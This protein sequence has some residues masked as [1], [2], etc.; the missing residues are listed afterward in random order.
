MPFNGAGSYSPPATDFPAVPATL[1]ESTKFNNVINDI[2]TALSTCI[3]KD[4]QTTVT[5]NIPFGG[6]RLTGVGAGTARTD[7]ANVGQLQDNTA[8]W[9]GTAAGTADAITLTPAPAIAAYVAGMSFVY[10]SG[11]AV[12]T[13]AMT[14]AISGL[15][16]KAIQ[17]NGGAL[18]A[19]DHPANRWF[20][21]VYDGAAFQ[22]N[23]VSWP[24]LAEL[25]T[26]KGDIIVWTGAGVPV[27]LAVGADTNLLV[28][29]STQP[30]GVKWSAF[31]LAAFGNQA[32]NTFLAGPASGAAATPGWRVGTAAD[33]M[34][35]VLL[36]TGT[37]SNSTSLDFTGLDG[38][39]D[40]HVFELVD[41]I[42]VNNGVNFGVRI[43]QDNGGS[44]KSG[45][46]DY[47]QML[48][49]I[50]DGGGVQSAGA[51]GTRIPLNSGTLSNATGG[52]SGRVVF[53]KLAGTTLRHEMTFQGTYRHSGPGMESVSG[54]G[55]YIIDTAAIN[56]IRFF[57]DTN[58]IS[59][60]VIRLFGRRKA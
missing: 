58:N 35:E 48:Y 43:S 15:A 46:A 12:N 52:W 60:G 22:L 6:F 30:G 40:E 37:A 45:A 42:A 39:Y 44:F 47:A 16:T 9:C 33:G 5:G 23:P 56:A 18:A 41:I 4:G 11:A 55:A 20:Q 53:K 27:R 14:V 54:G 31:A 24:V 59:S 50:N 28:A 19:G 25:G 57:M 21:I 51:Q 2:A 8:S 36:S 1:I 3:T 17:K 34:T 13:V 32:A 26:A 7:A 49:G 38:T 29:D 10:K